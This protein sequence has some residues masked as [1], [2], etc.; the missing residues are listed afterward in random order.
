MMMVLDHQIRRLAQ[1]CVD[2]DRQGLMHHVV[3][4]KFFIQAIFDS[5]IRSLSLTTPSGLPAALT[6]STERQPACVI[7]RAADVTGV[8]SRQTRIASDMT[9]ATYPACVF[10]SLAMLATKSEIEITPTLFRFP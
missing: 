1:T 7:V 4:G 8:L 5:A 2:V 3:Y 9:S 10:S 6:T